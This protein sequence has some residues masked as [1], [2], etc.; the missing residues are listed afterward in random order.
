MNPGRNVM[1][2]Q[3][4]LGYDN[5]GAVTSGNTMVIKEGYVTKQVKVKEKIKQK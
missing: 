1:M 3:E 2:R 4:N 5:E